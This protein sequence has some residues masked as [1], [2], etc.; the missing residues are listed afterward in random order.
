MT[1]KLLIDDF[2]NPTSEAAQHSLITI[3]GLVGKP[4]FSAISTTQLHFSIGNNW[5]SISGI[6]GEAANNVVAGTQIVQATLQS[7]IG[8][9][10]KSSIVP[11]FAEQYIALW[12]G[13]TIPTF[14]VDV[15]LV[16]YNDNDVRKDIMSLY[17]SVLPGGKTI[18]AGTILK[19]PLNYLPTTGGTQ[20]TVTVS[21][22]KWFRAS[23]LVINEVSTQFSKEVV[24][25]L[26]TKT[27]V[28]E[29]VPLYATATI[30][31]KPKKAITYSEFMGYFRNIR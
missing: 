17:S 25:V 11:I 13:P 20:G 27:Q 14:G 30:T 15:V 28:V 3:S 2:F 24:G 8:T 18:G 16:N 1:L 10:F 6:T 5:N 23:G 26:N 12:M 19:V 29:S 21:M 9:K 7:I 4:T 31:F 22:G